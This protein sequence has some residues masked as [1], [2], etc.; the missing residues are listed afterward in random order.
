[1][2][3]SKIHLRQTHIERGNYARV[4]EDAYFYERIGA[5]SELG[6]AGVGATAGTSTTDATLVGTNDVCASTA[7]GTTCVCATARAPGSCR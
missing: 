1:M 6:V 3:K 4:L 5:G 7:G 2:Q